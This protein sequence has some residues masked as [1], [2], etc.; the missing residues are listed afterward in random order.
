[1]T[2]NEASLEELLLPL[3]VQLVDVLTQLLAVRESME[4]SVRNGKGVADVDITGERVIVTR[5]DFIEAKMALLT[6]QFKLQGEQSS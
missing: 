3:R 6:A 4:T 1:M 2:A 5:R